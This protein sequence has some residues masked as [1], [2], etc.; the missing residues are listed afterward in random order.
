MWSINNNSL[1]LIR[2]IVLNPWY[3]KRQKF[4]GWKV[5]RFAGSI[6]YICGEKFRNFFPLCIHGFPTLQNSYEHFNESFAF[7]TWILLKTVISI[8]RNRWKYIA[9]T[10]VCT[11]FTLSRMTKQSQEENSE[12][13]YSWSESEMKQIANRFLDSFFCKLL[14]NLL[15]ETL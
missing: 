12:K 4:Q 10:W 11:D 14:P 15:A 5:S 8:L 7:L 2:Q 13:S 3:R 9:E 6:R 1:R